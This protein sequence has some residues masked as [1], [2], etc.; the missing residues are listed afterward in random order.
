MLSGIDMN[1]SDTPIRVRLNG[2][3]RHLPA[4]LTLAALLAQLGIDPRQVA[5]ELDREVVPRADFAE[6]S[7]RDGAEIEIVHFVGGG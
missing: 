1:T 7:V 2:E 5:V 4:G 6:R 3:E